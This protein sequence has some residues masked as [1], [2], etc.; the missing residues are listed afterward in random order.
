LALS[1]NAT[2]TFATMGI[3]SNRR[4]LPYRSG[5]GEELD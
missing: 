5:L 1:I 3:V 4:D 2:A